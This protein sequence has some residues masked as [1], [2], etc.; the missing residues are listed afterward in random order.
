MNY[1]SFQAFTVSIRKSFQRQEESIQ[2]NMTRKI[3][4]Q[5]PLKTVPI[6]PN[7]SFPFLRLY[8]SF[9][10]FG[11]TRAPRHN[12]ETQRTRNKGDNSRVQAMD[13]GSAWER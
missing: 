6:K 13:L 4:V 11:M 10:Q 2:P 9:I 5:D 1:Y 8:G 3:H 7:Q 12:I